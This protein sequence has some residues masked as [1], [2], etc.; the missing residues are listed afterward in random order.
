MHAPGLRASWQ[1]KEF[2]RIFTHDV[3][4]LLLREMGSVGR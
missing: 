4:P 1:L 3:L 2:G